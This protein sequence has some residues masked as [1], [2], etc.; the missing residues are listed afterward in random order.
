MSSLLE[1]WLGPLGNKTLNIN[2]NAEKEHKHKQ[3]PFEQ[4]QK[5]TSALLGI[6]FAPSAH[7]LPFPLLVSCFLNLQAWLRL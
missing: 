7:Q 5:H 3:L 4:K 6:S 2:A 1:Y